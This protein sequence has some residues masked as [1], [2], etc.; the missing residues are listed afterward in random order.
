MID[1]TA[2]HRLPASMRST[3]TGP[4]ARSR[5]IE[6]WVGACALASGLLPSRRRPP[7]SVLIGP[8]ANRDCPRSRHAIWLP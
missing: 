1:L 2:D 3:L 8:D 5:T 7:R 6:G 4:T